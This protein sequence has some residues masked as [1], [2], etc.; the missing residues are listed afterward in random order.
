MQY[1]WKEFIKFLD[2]EDMKDEA[3]GR[4]TT[5]MPQDAGQRRTTLFNR[6]QKTVT[7]MTPASVERDTV[8]ELVQSIYRIRSPGQQS[9]CQ[10]SPR[11]L[12]STSGVLFKVV[13]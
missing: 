2:E 5:L 10:R 7:P 11:D 3:A 1:G 8:P 4:R 13:R 6:P 12:A 9:F